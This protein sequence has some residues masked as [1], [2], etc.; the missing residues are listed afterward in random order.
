[1]RY[2]PNEKKI[3]DLSSITLTTH[4]VSIGYNTEN[5]ISIF[6]EK[7]SSLEAKYHHNP[8][9]LLL[10]GMFGFLTFALFVSNNKDGF[11]LPAIIITVLPIILYFTTRQYKI[12][13]RSAGASIEMGASN[14]KKETLF[15]F[16]DELEEAKNARYLGILLD[17]EKTKPVAQTHKT[18]YKCGSC[19]HEHR[20]SDAFCEKCGSKLL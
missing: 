6:L 12:L 10:S 7:I 18:E 15:A 11:V 19:G 16:I 8:V 9:L 14:I 20:K 17:T 4:R 3:T 5:F 1:M 2:L 13:I